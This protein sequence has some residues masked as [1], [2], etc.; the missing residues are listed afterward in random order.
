MIST[1]VLPQ[2]FLNRE[3]AAQIT[4][5][6]DIWADE[7]IFV[8]VASYRDP[9]IA[10]TVARAFERAADP[11]RVFFGIF[12]QNDESKDVDAVRDDIR[13]RFRARRATRRT[14]IARD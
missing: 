12:Q 7:S 3:R 1:Q 13:F 14:T 5:T 10:K 6:K 8:S 11:D 9:E 4:K 2:S